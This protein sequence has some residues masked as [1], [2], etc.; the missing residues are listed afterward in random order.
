MSTQNNII[1]IQQ[2]NNHTE[3]N[4]QFI[5]SRYKGDMLFN[6]FVLSILWFFGIQAIISVLDGT[7]SN[8]TGFLIFWL[9]GISVITYLTIET[10]LWLTKGVEKIY[11]DHEKIT[12]IQY[13][14]LYL[15]SKNHKEIQTILFKD[16]DKIYYSEYQVVKSRLPRPSKGNIHLKNRVSKVS[17]GINLNRNEAEKILKEIHSYY[18]ITN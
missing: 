11:L 1:Q 14:P 7:D 17:F 13:I 9:L 18:T 6:F 2:Q 16:L 10:S 8:A 12:V 15:F 5:K 3:I 4:I